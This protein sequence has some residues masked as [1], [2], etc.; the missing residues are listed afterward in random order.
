LWRPEQPMRTVFKPRIKL[1]EGSI[2][3][4]SK[5]VKNNFK[6]VRFEVYNFLNVFN[7]FFVVL[8]YG[9]KWK[10]CDYSMRLCKDMTN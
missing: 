1:D 7:L 8:Q 2:K 6:V 10:G 4:T 5:Q 3:C 9:N